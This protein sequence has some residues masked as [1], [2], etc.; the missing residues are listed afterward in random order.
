[1]RSIV[2][3]IGLLVVAQAGAQSLSRE[4]IDRAQALYANGLTLLASNKV[5]EAGTEFQKVIDLNPEHR[6]ALY[7]MA[8]VNER[9]GDSPGAIRLLVKAMKLNDRRAS[10]ELARRH[11]FKLSYA[12][13]MQNIDPVVRDKYRALST[14]SAASFQDLSKQIIAAATG[15]REQ[16]QLL[17]LWTFDHMN[18]DSVRFFQGGAPFSSD[19]A[20]ARR[21]GLCDEYSNLMTDF[22]KQAGILN[23]KVPGYVRY[24]TFKAGDSFTEANHAWNAVY[25]D[26]SWLLCDLF[27]STVALQAGDGSDS[28]FV[29]L[30][31]PGYFLSIPS[32]FVNQHLPAD[33]VFQFSNYPI[34]FRS[35][36]SKVQGFDASEPRM[37]YLNYEDSLK[38]FSAIG[39]PERGL[40]IAHHSYVYNPDNASDLIVTSYN[41]AVDVLGDPS[42]KRK[43]WTAARKSLAFSMTII[44][45][46]PNGEIRALKGSCKTAMSMLDRRLAAR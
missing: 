42:S 44:D 19:E 3:F 28:R 35:F 43:E 22:C 17:L 1:M 30:L 4:R 34:T 36:I 13:T 39:E 2:I 32:D 26:S 21:T 10:R 25:I 16:L 15:K 31:E 11:G 5:F 9:L 12:D 41:Y 40:R 29:R 20:F 7:Q 45:E 18:A 24:P 14:V 38:F 37:S 46:S 33:P 6:D 23:Y 27:W 8:M